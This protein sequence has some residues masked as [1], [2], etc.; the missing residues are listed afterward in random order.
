[1]IWDVVATLEEMDGA[2]Y[3]YH[4]EGKKNSIGS[5]FLFCASNPLRFVS[6]AIHSTLFWVMVASVLWNLEG[7]RRCTRLLNPPQ[8][9]GAQTTNL[10]A[11]GLNL[12]SLRTHIIGKSLFVSLSKRGKLRAN[13]SKYGVA[14]LP[15]ESLL[16]LFASVSYLKKALGFLLFFLASTYDTAAL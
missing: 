14:E 10:A 4:L 12:E 2:S 13:L 6:R 11:R 1:M 7:C 3:P 15:S 5:L 16:F 8:W 9:H